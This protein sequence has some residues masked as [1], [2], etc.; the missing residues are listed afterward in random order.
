MT[1][2][3][4]RIK[5][6]DIALRAED[7]TKTVEPPVDWEEA[8]KALVLL[9]TTGFVSSATINGWVQQIHDHVDPRAAKLMTDVFNKSRSSWMQDFME[10]AHKR[11]VA[12]E[13]N[14]IIALLTERAEATREWDGQETAVSLTYRKAI[15]AIQTKEG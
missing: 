4:R 15:E 1:N 8:F 9:S 3:V 12:A 11:G 6:P 2:I 5:E 10:R 14:R 13:R 7:P